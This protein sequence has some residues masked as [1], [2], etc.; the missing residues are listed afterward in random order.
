MPVFEASSYQ[1]ESTYTPQIQQSVKELRQSQSQRVLPNILYTLPCG[2]V[3]AAYKVV[4]SF[5][6]LCGRSFW[7]EATIKSCK[8][9]HCYV[10]QG[11]KEDINSG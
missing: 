1:E 7:A 5:D 9:K 2:C 4:Y 8:V 6:Y 11:R 3:Y 10:K